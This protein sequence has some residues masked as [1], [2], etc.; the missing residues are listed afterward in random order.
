LAALAQTMNAYAYGMA[1]ASLLA[2]ATYANI[3]LAALWGYLLFG[4][5]PGATTW[6]G[7]LLIIAG[8]VWLARLGERAPVEKI[9][10]VAP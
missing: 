7:A 8:G 9:P 2:P 4:E 10:R 6:A 5:V 3:V 1:R